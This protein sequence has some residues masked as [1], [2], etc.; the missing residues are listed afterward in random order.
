IR[1]VRHDG[2]GGGRHPH[3]HGGRRGAGP[4]PHGARDA[5][6]RRGRPPRLPR[7]PHAAPRGGGAVVADH[8][9]ARLTT[10]AA[11]VTPARRA[12]YETLRATREGQ[13]ADRAF[14]RLLA[15]VPARERAFAHELTYGTL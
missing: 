7:R 4:G 13:L 10:A 9:H 1:R 3:E 12:A 11:T 8:R 15:Q 5:L 14:A 6:R 2:A